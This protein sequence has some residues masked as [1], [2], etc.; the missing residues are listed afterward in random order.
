MLLRLIDDLLDLFPHRSRPGSRLQ[1]ETSCHGNGCATSANSMRIP[2]RNERT[3]TLTLALADNLPDHWWTDP[4]PAPADSA[5][6]CCGPPSGS[7]P[8]GGSSELGAVMGRHGRGRGRL[9]HFRCPD[10]ASA[11]PRTR[12]ERI[13]DP[14]TQVDASTGGRH[15]WHGPGPCYLQTSGRAARR[16]IQLDS[17]LGPGLALHGHPAP[18]NSLPG[19]V[20][21]PHPSAVAVATSPPQG[22]RLLLVEARC[23]TA[24]LM[25]LFLEDE[26]LQ[27]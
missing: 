25:K 19:G 27:P 8:Q 16:R 6:I 22:L 24:E 26:P 9:P 7:T 2:D 5:S 17:T 21:T 1:P 20:R 15:G 4:A 3:W 14:F 13:F 11:S 10:T 23:R 12:A 18:Q